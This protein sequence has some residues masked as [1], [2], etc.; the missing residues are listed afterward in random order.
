MATWHVGQWGSKVTSWT[1][2][3]TQL[4]GRSPPTTHSALPALC[5]RWTIQQRCRTSNPGRK[6]KSVREMNLTLTTRVLQMHMKRW[7]FYKMSCVNLS[8]QKISK[9][10]SWTSP[11]S[12]SSP[13]HLWKPPKI[14]SRTPAASVCLSC[15]K[16]KIRLGFCLASLS[17]SV[18]SSGPSSSRQSPRKLLRS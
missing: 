18:S 11:L 14:S 4:V 13:S 2:L 10:P 12:S 16:P 1:P 6:R 9:I 17:S 8:W 5:E 3:L 15:P 7:E